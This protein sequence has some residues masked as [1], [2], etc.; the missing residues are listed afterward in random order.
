MKKIVLTFGIIADYIGRVR[1][2]AKACCEV[3]LAGEE[4]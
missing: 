2:L 3:W 1:T 4:A